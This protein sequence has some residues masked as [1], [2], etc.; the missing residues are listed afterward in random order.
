MEENR[1]ISTRIAIEWLVQIYQF[2]K[3]TFTGGRS[4]GHFFIHLFTI[5][6]AQIPDYELLAI[7]N[8]T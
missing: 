7:E 4:S 2:D 8:R 6:D 1:R 3:D 5:L